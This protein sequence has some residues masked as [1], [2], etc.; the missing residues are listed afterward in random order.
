MKKY[1]SL[2]ATNFASAIE[3]RANLFSILL[4]EAISVS[5]VLILWVAVYR[6][7]D[8][9]AGYNFN[10][11]ITYYLMV[12][13][14]GFV[15][16]VVL[17][18]K[19]ASEIRTGFFSNYLLKP[20]RFWQAAFMSVLATKVNYLILVSPVIAAV[21]IYVISKGL[22][23][24]TPIA[25]LS[26]L[27]IALLAFVFHFA[28]DLAISFAAFW[29]DDVWAF[30]H[31]KNITF[32]ILGG[33]SFPLDFVTG[34]LKALFTFLPFQYLYYVPIMYLLGKRSGFDML[35]SDILHLLA[36]TVVVAF[37]AAILWRLG[38]RKYGAYGR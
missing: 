26:A 28:L 24:I 2:F 8:S 14:V 23:H 5:S 18:D 27:L 16:Q 4:L 35:L 31:I 11:A 29:L 30:T 1:T 20:L 3:Y 38:L 32:S 25:L 9:V 15:T 34:P 6:S 19:L 13:I 21:L 12:P 22:I 7:Q 10:D 36:W 37:L 33:L 17:S